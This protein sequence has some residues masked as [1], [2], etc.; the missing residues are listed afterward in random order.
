MA[1]GQVE[2]LIN[3]FCT[4]TCL[5][6]NSSRRIGGIDGV[7]LHCTDP[8]KASQRMYGHVDEGWD[9]LVTDEGAECTTAN[10]CPFFL[11]A[12]ELPRYLLK[13]PLQIFFV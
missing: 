3:P 13:Q 6:L 12:T 7:N 1:R 5:I 10:E 9:R 8:G 4:I 11:I 2:S